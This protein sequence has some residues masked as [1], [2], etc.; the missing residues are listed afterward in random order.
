VK[1]SAVFRFG[2]EKDFRFPPPKSFCNYTLWPRAGQGEIRLDNPA[3]GCS[4]VLN[5]YKEAQIHGSVC[6]K[7][8][9]LRL[10]ANERYRHNTRSWNIQ[11][12]GAGR[13][14]GTYKW[15]DRVNRRSCYKSPSGCIIYYNEQDSSWRMHFKEDLTG[16][17]FQAPMKKVATRYVGNMVGNSEPPRTGW[18]PANGLRGCVPM[19]IFQ[20]ALMQR[21]VE[22]EDLGKMTQA[23]RGTEEEKDLIFRKSGETT[24]KAEWHRLKWPSATR[25]PSATFVWAE[26]VRMAQAEILKTM[27]FSMS[28][29]VVVSPQGTPAHGTWECLVSLGPKG[30]EEPDSTGV[31][32]HVINLQ[33]TEELLEVF[34]PMTW[35]DAG[36]GAL[37]TARIHDIYSWVGHCE[38]PVPG[39]VIERGFG[40]LR[41]VQLDLDALTR[42]D[43]FWE[44]QEQPE[45]AEI[46]KS[47]SGRWCSRGARCAFRL[48]ASKASKT[49]NLWL[50]RN[51]TGP[52]QRC[53]KGQYD[54]A[55]RC[56]TAVATLEGEDKGNAREEMKV[57]LTMSED[58]LNL[59]G[60]L[61][62]QEITFR[63]MIDS[64]SFL[65]GS[66]EEQ[67][68]EE[69]TSLKQIVVTYKKSHKA[70]EELHFAPLDPT[71]PFTPIVLEG[72]KSPTGPAQD[73]GVRAG[74]YLDIM[75]TFFNDRSEV[76]EEIVAVDSKCL[77]SLEEAYRRI[78]SLYKVLL[79]SLDKAPLRL[80]FINAFKV[81][82]LPEA[83]IS[84]KGS[85]LRGEL[86][87]LT[88]IGAILTGEGF[89]RS[90]PVFKAGVRAGWQVDVEQSL[91]QTQRRLGLVNAGPPED[92]LKF[93]LDTS[94]ERIIRFTTEARSEVQVVSAEN[95]VSFPGVDSVVVRCQRPDNPAARYLLVV[96]PTGPD[97]VAPEK[98]QL[99]KLAEGWEESCDRLYG[100]KGEEV[101]V[102]RDGWDEVRLRALCAHHGW[103]FSW[104][105]ED[106]ERR[107]RIAQGGVN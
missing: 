4:N 87:A 73:A 54:E 19:E 74:W 92:A 60:T 83:E 9:V 79:S 86:G 82:Q 81:E 101:S 89:Q 56:F 17:V 13:C 34:S 8:H 65:W 80:V 22:E 102:E 50:L 14:N 6:L 55:T 69:T 72:F 58:G 16:F 57:A 30:N 28:S 62:A 100:L 103:E 49:G 37:C 53:L 64:P 32:A 71:K 21:G 11:V 31:A 106:D 39:T 23:L 61:D 107:R 98:E 45:G 26:V 85:P 25:P 90:S 46:E 99:Q 40:T 33:G 5:I 35:Y 24:F 63:R 41:R 12:T 91:L 84:S 75:E 67:H 10:V 2:P 36:A 77:D 47:I 70:S 15:S 78:H 3:V 42:S 29:T 38:D 18:K 51:Q 48:G 93:L 27:G 105:T 66:A 97:H 44:L 43:L 104:M 95:P 59:T 7:D 88:E 76:F 68:F 96:C 52:Q 20:R 94:E 1:G